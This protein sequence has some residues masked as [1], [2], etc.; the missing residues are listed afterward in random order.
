M[1]V[2]FVQTSVELGIAGKRTL[3][4]FRV[5]RP[6]RPGHKSHVEASVATAAEVQLDPELLPY[7][8]DECGYRLE[9]H[10]RRWVQSDKN[11]ART[12]TRGPVDGGLHRRVL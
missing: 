9:G 11:S 3:Q 2:Q 6:A 10:G 5:F 4:A 8:V 7:I 12:V 1:E